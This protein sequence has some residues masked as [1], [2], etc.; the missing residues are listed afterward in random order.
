LSRKQTLHLS[1]KGSGYWC[2]AV[3]VLYKPSLSSHA[4]AGGAA[5]VSTDRHQKNDGF[6]D[7]QILPAT[8]PGPRAVPARTHCSLRPA[9]ATARTIIECVMRDVLRDEYRAGR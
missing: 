6:I 4:F 9:P 1:L 7:W 2:C 8:I 5:M 3:G